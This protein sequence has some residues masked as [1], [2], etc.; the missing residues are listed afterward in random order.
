MAS[1]DIV[2]WT[3]VGVFFYG[4]YLLTSIGLNLT[5]RTEYYPVSTAIR[6]GLNIALNLVLVP[7]VGI[8]GAAWANGAA[9]AIQA[10][11]AC[12]LAQ[13]FYPVTYEYGRLARAVAAGGAAYVVARLLPLPL[14]LVGLFVR[15][16][17]VVVVMGG[18][19]WLTGFFDAEELQS[20]NARRRRHR[21]GSV[22]APPSDTTELA[23][24]IVAT[25]V[26]GH[27]ADTPTALGTA[28][29]KEGRGTP[30]R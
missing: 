21:A 6:R 10:G 14:G 30:T 28:A 18:L 19:L 26:S 25:D 15:G 27:E 5:S 4:I 17:T 29:A 7:R 22:M 12:S 9:Y 23:G 20:L 2:A 8:I 11:V 3:A 16:A 1:A 13:R 24:E